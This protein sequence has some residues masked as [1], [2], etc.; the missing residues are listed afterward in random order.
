VGGQ[1]CPAPK[2]P[3]VGVPELLWKLWMHRIGAVESVSSASRPALPGW[4]PRDG[5]TRDVPAAGGGRAGSPGHPG[6]WLAP[7][8]AAG[9]AG[10]HVSPGQASPAA[11]PTG[12]SLAGAQRPAPPAKPRRFPAPGDELGKDPAAPVRQRSGAGG[13]AGQPLPRIDF[14]VNL[15]PRAERVNPP[16]PSQ[17]PAHISVFGQNPQVW[18]RGCPSWASPSQPPPRHPGQPCLARE[19]RDRARLLTPRRWELLVAVASGFF[20]KICFLSCFLRKLLFS[21]QR[22]P[23]FPSQ[24]NSI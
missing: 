24:G 7:G 8:Q 13:R 12:A 17:P 2:P 10:R 16:F 20:E 19:C 11:A 14:S 15:P 1:R 21:L 5:V 9:L 3:G 4:A 18:A 6:A 23:A 22:A